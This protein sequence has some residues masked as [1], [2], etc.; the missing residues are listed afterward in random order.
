M[1]NN[2]VPVTNAQVLSLDVIPLNGGTVAA[3]IND[4]REI[5]M[6]NGVVVNDPQLVKNN[7]DSVRCQVVMSNDVVDNDV[8]V[9]S[10]V[11]NVN[12]QMVTANDEVLNDLEV[13]TESV[14][15]VGNVNRQVIMPNGMILNDARLMMN[16]GEIKSI[17]KDRLVKKEQYELELKS[18][19]LNRKR[20]IMSTLFCDGSGMVS[21]YDFDVRFFTRWSS[22]PFKEMLVMN[23]DRLK[24]SREKYNYIIKRLSDLKTIW[25]FDRVESTDKELL[26]HISFVMG[27]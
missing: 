14:M 23:F 22:I 5:I 21:A 2:G 1:T 24:T 8:Q 10:D 6:P 27:D 25:Y 3:M 18:K 7:D 17:I 9:M 26:Y 16:N 11:F 4:G 12:Q 15:G 19:L 13:V 20:L